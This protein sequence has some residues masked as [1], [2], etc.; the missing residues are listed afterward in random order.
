MTD[1]RLPPKT[2]AARNERRKAAAATLNGTGTATGLE[3]GRLRITKRARKLADLLGLDKLS[4]HIVRRRDAAAMR[5]AVHSPHDRSDDRDRYPRGAPRLWNDR[6]DDPRDGGRGHRKHK[7]HDIP[8]R[9]PTRHSW[10]ARQHAP[11]H[12]TSCTSGERPKF[13]G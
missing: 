1:G 3:L 10:H 11:S 4:L 12:E 2:K 6:E 13:R 7:H 8:H 9:S 5:E